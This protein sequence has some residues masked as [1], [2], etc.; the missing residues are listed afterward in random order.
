[1]WSV[2]EV[3]VDTHYRKCSEDQLCSV[4][5]HFLEGE[6]PNLRDDLSIN[7]PKLQQDGLGPCF[8][9]PSVG[10]ARVL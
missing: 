7:L 1:M 3:P 2:W 6:P 5:V 10:P 9:T 4:G 8:V